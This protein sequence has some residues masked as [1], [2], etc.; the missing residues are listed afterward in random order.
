MAE[1]DRTNERVT[2][3]VNDIGRAFTPSYHVV[4]DNPG[5]IAP[6]RWEHVRAP[7]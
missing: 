1:L 5:R 3:G 6:E 4:V 7:Q 2:V